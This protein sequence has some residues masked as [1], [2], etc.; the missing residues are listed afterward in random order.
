MGGIMSHLGLVEDDSY[1]R[2]N[3]SLEASRAQLLFPKDFN[4]KF[5]H[6]FFVLSSE[7]APLQTKN[8]LLSWARQGGFIF[9]GARV[10]T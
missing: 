2:P 7:I 8:F 6:L 3:I 1:A 5:A 10:G 9:F 4:S